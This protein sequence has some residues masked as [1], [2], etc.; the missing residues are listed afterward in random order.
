M[1]FLDCPWQKALL[2]LPYGSESRE[3][4]PVVDSVAASSIFR[5]CCD[6]V[7]EPRAAAFVLVDFHISR[8]EINILALTLLRSSP[9]STGACYVASLKLFS[10]ILS[11]VV[12]QFFYSV[13]LR[14]RRVQLL[15]HQVIG[16]ENC[17]HLPT[18][19]Q[20]HFKLPFDC[21]A[22]I[23]MIFPIVKFFAP[24]LSISDFK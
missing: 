5:F 23:T 21:R 14:P 19:R 3:K 13:S 1:R 10:D 4:S 7:K 12:L 22:N 17:P 2:S 11:I 24:L 18:L 8:G 16:S 20:V 6:G 9:S 15:E